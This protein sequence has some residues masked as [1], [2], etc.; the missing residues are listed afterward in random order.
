MPI[1]S[2]WNIDIPKISLPRLLFTSS[3]GPLPN[4]DIFFDAESPAQK[5]TLDSFRLWSQRFAAGLRHAGLQDGDRVL[6]FS[7]NNIFFP[8]VFMGVIMAGGIFTAAN[9]SYVARELAHQ[10]RVTEPLFLLCAPTS[11]EIGLEAASQ[12]SL[13]RNRVFAFEAIP[14]TG[15]PGECESRMGCSHWSTLIASA[16]EGKAF[17]WK[18]SA[19]QEDECQRTIVL[20]SSSG[21]TGL[22]KCVEITHYSYVSTVLMMEHFN[23]LPENYPLADGLERWLCFLPLY[24]AMGQT[25]FISLALRR[26][27]PV[28]IMAQFD[29]TKMLDYVQEFRITKLIV[30]PGILVA[31]TK[32]P[33]VRRGD[34]DLSSVWHISCGAAPLAESVIQE[35]QDHWTGNKDVKINQGYGMTE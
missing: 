21:T 16:I 30:V 18:E 32:D 24:H 11:L 17:L 7:P 34:W 15:V 8:V 26:Q 10:L 13:P 2:R 29:F 25:V 14:N 31:L 4:I 28:Y 1:K 5:L 35:I 3:T 6:L 23:K 27:I 33:R 12:V 20:N 19:S 9:P 22:P